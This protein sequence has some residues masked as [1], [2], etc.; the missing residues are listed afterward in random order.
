MA[1]DRIRVTVVDRGRKYLY[2]RY[3]DP[4]TGKT[5]EKSS[6]VP[7]GRRR[8][9]ERAAAKW[10]KEL[11]DDP[12]AV[13]T[14]RLRR[15]TWREFRQRHETEQLASLATNTELEYVST[16]NVLESILPAVRDGRLHDLTAGRI[17][18]LQRE[19]RARE[20]AEATIKKHLS[21]LRAALN[22][23]RRMGMLRDVPAIQMPKRARGQKHMKGRPITLEEFER[24]LAKVP[25]VVLTRPRQRR[26]RIVLSLAR[27]QAAGRPSRTLAR[28]LADCDRRARKIVASWRFL[29]RGLWHSG[30]RLNEAMNLRW[31]DEGLLSVDFRGRRPVFRIR[32]EGQKSGKDQTLPMAPEFAE[33]L[34]AVPARRRRGFVFDPVAQRK[35]IPRMRSDSVSKVITEIGRAAKV[36]VAES[37]AGKVKYASAHDL[38]RA[39]GDRWSRRL[40]PADL[41]QLMRHESIETTMRFYVGSEA[42]S[43]ADRLWHA[44]G[45][46][47]GDT[48]RNPAPK[49]A[50]VS[51]SKGRK[52]KLQREF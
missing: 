23:A 45:D 38:R 32:G 36:K 18:A 33:F 28:E 42:E 29:L 14:M 35:Q 11:E 30:L 48:P 37:P 50:P 12:A 4:E 9:A 16:Y 6:G 51:H 34:A 8:D 49:T 47:S 22:W 41:Q 21:N 25:A 26:T 31:T 24:M 20:L 5:I 52:S 44:V 15:I 27:A 17:S 13:R 10:E 1:D 46:T 3:R 39:F 7:R 19:L 2:L 43:I 40:M